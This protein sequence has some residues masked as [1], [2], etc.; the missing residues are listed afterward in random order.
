M[1]EK[2]SL[3]DALFNQQKV[4]YLAV[5]IT[6]AYPTFKADKFVSQIIKEFPN[7]ELKQRITCIREQL[8]RQLPGDFEGAL[9]I[10][11]KT[12]PR[13]LD[14][15]KTDDDFG[16]F[17]FAPLADFVAKNGLENRY[18]SLSFNAL[19][20]MTKRFSCEYAIRYFINKYPDESFVFMKNMSKSNN[21]HQRRLASEGLR[22]R[23]PWCIGIKFEH[24]K[25]IAILDTLYFDKTR[26]VVRSVAN[27]LNDI[28]KFDANLVIKTLEKWQ[29]EDRQ[30]NKREFIFLMQHSLRTL[31]KQGNENAL[32]MLGY[33][34]NPKISIENFECKEV[35]ITLGNYLNF[36]FTIK[37]KQDEKLM[38]D[39]KIIYPTHNQRK[40][41][42][43]FKIK[44]I[45]LKEN[46]LIVIQKKHLFRVMS[47]RKL[48]P[49]EYKIQLQINGKNFA[50]DK[51]R[52]I[53]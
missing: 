4:E 44:K 5:L 23:L 32:A 27:H 19:A 10:L 40:S 43:V 50:E 39:Y 49:G 17:I 15:D 14:P 6:G 28:A 24:Q 29:K 30:K 48:Y 37:A 8:E 51:F 35:Q 26:F 12:L 9:I 11:L 2:F 18:L 53:F 36:S 42:K 16:D 41:E 38:I 22:P 46:A 1:V 31:V 47:S 52:L 7:L 21:Y 13:E 20:Q 45:T 3:K 34:S 25:A 33:Q